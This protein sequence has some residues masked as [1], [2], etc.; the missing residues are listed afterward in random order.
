MRTGFLLCYEFDIV[1]M[2]K[3]FDISMWKTLDK[4]FVSVILLCYATHHTETKAVLFVFLFRSSSQLGPETRG[5]RPFF[6]IPTDLL[7]V[8]PTCIA[9]KQPPSS[10]GY[11][12]MAG[13]L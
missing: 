7:A 10:D 3:K 8:R 4:I 9:G 6:E 12:L 2:L 5:L 11:G 1:S 13:N